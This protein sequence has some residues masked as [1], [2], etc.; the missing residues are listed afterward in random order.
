MRV[1]GVSLDSS[2]STMGGHE[3]TV[4]YAG[5]PEQSGRHTPWQ[6]IWTVYCGLGKGKSRLG[7]IN[8]EKDLVKVCRVVVSGR[9]KYMI[10]AKESGQ[11][12]EVHLCY[13]GRV[14][15]SRDKCQVRDG[16]TLMLPELY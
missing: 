2:R 15:V 11:S 14:R 3:S 7:L 4:I 8:K 16:V 1:V 6:L 13:R 9:L 12:L 5:A 10:V